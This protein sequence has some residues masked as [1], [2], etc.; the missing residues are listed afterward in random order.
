MRVSLE[1]TSYNVSLVSR[2]VRYNITESGGR[3]ICAEGEGFAVTEDVAQV[4]K[5]LDAGP[6]LV[7]INGNSARARSSDTNTSFRFAFQ[8]LESTLV[9]LE[10]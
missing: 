9:I 7:P 8:P 4:D 10:V 1:G 5:E 2:Q 3:G 6:Y